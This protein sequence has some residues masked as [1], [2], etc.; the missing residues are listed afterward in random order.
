VAGS[1]RHD[2]REMRL[3]EDLERA[4]LDAWDARLGDWA[5]IGD[6]FRG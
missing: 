6:R 5:L 2:K 1:S 4:L 3:A